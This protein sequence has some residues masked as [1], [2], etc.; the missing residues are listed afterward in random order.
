MTS[1]EITSRAIKFERPE[2]IPLI[3][4]FLETTDV[5]CFGLKPLP[6]QKSENEDEWG[7]VWE[8]PCRGSGT[9][10]MG[11]VKNPPMKNLDE[12]DYYSFPDPTD[13]ARYKEIEGELKKGGDKYKLFGWFTLFEKAQQL[14]GT[15]TL[16]LALYDQPKKVHKLLERIN[17]FT[18]AVLDNLAPYK[19]KI[20][21]FRIGDDWGMQNSLLL[22]I[23]LFREFFKRRYREILSKAHS[24]GM[25]VWLHSDGKINEVIEEFIDIGLDVIN[26]QSPHVLG[27]EEI[28]KRYCGRIAFECTVDIQRTLPFGSKKEI[29]NEARMLISKWGAQNGGF[30]ASDYGSTLDDHLA[31]GA[32]RERVR[33]MLEAFKRYGGYNGI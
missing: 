9:I 19:E 6:G 33:W 20:H 26:I 8:K 10:N 17:D 30:I 12:I 15:S 23:K 18:L 1:Y 5:H 13:T 28:S 4:P 16:F 2:R 27:I 32:S 3:F 31:I 29:E 14:Y 24:L 25:D 11:Q 22:S 21:G 7:V